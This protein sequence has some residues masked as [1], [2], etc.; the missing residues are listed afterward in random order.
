MKEMEDNTNKWKDISGVPFLAQWLMNPTRIHEDMGS[1]PGLSWWVG[2][3]A[4]LWAVVYVTDADWI[5]NCCGCGCGTGQWCSSDSIPSLGTSICH[6]CSHKKKKKK[7]KGAKKKDISH[8]WIKIFNIVK[9]FTL[10]N[11]MCLDS[12]ISYQ[13]L[14][15]TN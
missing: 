8:L 1:I 9:M 4:L 2:D 13:A 5:L 10:P 3:L 14:Y 11:A 12:M 6:R 15:D 7:K